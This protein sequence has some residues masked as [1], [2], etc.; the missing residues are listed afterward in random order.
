MSEEEEAK[1]V[2]GGSPECFAGEANESVR[3]RALPLK[4]D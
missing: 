2:W 1:N 3:G 4:S